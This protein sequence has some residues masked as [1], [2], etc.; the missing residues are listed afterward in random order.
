M[1]LVDDLWTEIIMGRQK[2]STRPPTW[3]IKVSNIKNNK[4]VSGKL[5]RRFFFL[6]NNLLVATVPRYFAWRIVLVVGLLS[7]L[8]VILIMYSGLAGSIFYRVII[9]N[10]LTFFISSRA[11]EKLLKSERAKIKSFISKGSLS[12]SD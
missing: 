3:V 12:K 5:Q 1:N 4:R 6:V 10:S 11:M 9:N 8:N 7:G 2:I